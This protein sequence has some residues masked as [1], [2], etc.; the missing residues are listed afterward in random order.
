MA[1][2]R[3]MVTQASLGAWYSVLSHVLVHFLFCTFQNAGPNSNPRLSGVVTLK[4]AMEHVEVLSH[5]HR[6]SV[7]IPLWRLTP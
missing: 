2:P 7:F 4:T 6:L 1:V 3:V 5:G